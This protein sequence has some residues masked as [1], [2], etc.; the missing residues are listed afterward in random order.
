MG[1]VGGAGRE[2]SWPGQEGSKP[3]YHYR[4]FSPDALPIG[5]PLSRPYFLGRFFPVQMLQRD[6]IKGYVSCKGR[7]QPQK[8][9][10]RYG[11]QSASW[12]NSLLLSRV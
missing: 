8:E 1:G 10:L 12:Q 4:K 11:T 5:H 7:C 6:D 2:F 3:W 9:R